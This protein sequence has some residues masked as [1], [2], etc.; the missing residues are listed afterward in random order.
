[1]FKKYQR[2][3]GVA[4]H[5]LAPAL[6]LSVCPSSRHIWFVYY[7]NSSA[8]SESRSCCRSCCSDAI[9]SYADEDEDEDDEEDDE[10]EAEAPEAATEEEAAAAAAGCTEP[11]AL[12]PDRCRFN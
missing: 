4:F 12:S 7:E 6:L 1:M 3:V 2:C 5:S 8:N 10:A 9:G 11:N